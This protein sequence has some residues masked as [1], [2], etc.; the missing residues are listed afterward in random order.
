[1]MASEEI[2]RSEIIRSMHHLSTWLAQHL[3]MLIDVG[4]VF[5]RAAYDELRQ[6]FDISPKNLVV[7]IFAEICEPTSFKIVSDQFHARVRRNQNGQVR[8]LNF[9]C[10]PREA[11]CALGPRSLPPIYPLGNPHW[12]PQSAVRLLRRTRR[13]DPG[14]E[15]CRF[16]RDTGDYG[17]DTRRCDCG[18]P[19][20][21]TRCGT[22]EG[23]RDEAQGT[24][25]AEEF[26]ATPSARGG[27][28]G[29]C[30]VDKIRSALGI[31]YSKALHY[32]IGHLRRADDGLRP[33]KDGEPGCSMG[34]LA[35][36][37]N[38]RC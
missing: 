25:R 29:E 18:D 20:N 28:P 11:Q 16:Y 7:M 33:K 3:R 21:E 24:D 8:H 31:E 32:A 15:T 1:M 23:N 37:D 5:Y 38:H 13:G 14:E 19:G 6:A 27:G 10:G 12:S 2:I 17:G 36:G 9:V 34:L 22:G 35:G 26:R 4:C 30:G